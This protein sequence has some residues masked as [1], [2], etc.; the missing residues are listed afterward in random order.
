[1]LNDVDKNKM[2][3]QVTQEYKLCPYSFVRLILE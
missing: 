1:M 3:E 2:H